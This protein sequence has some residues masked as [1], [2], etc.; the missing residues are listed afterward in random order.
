MKIDVWAHVGT[1]AYKAHLE[2]AAR[3]GPGPGSFLLGNRALH[4]LEFRFEVMDRYDDYQQV[5][6][7]IPGPHVYQDLAGQQLI[8]LVR[9]NNDEMAEITRH[10][11]D[12]FAGFVA[13]T[14]LAEPEAAAAEADPRRSRA[15]RSRGSAGGGP[16]RLPSA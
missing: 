2:A 15:G 8:D 6:L 13:A 11:P 12:R 16:P 14:P 9:A 4:D 10:H 3:Q 1:P 5:L 7:P